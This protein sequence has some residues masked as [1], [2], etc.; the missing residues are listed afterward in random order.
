MPTDLKT[1]LPDL[2]AFDWNS[3]DERTS[4]LL[5]IVSEIYDEYEINESDTSWSTEWEEISDQ[6]VTLF[7][8]DD[9][10]NEKNI[11]KLFEIVARNLPYLPSPVRDELL[12]AMEDYF[13]SLVQFVA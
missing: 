11:L 7:K 8:E 12:A 13:P 9:S 4:S 5:G 2:T 10:Q 3:F 1:F 6:I